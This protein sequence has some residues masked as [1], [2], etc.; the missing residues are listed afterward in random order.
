MGSKRISIGIAG[1][2]TAGLVASLMLRTAFPRSEITVIASSDIGIVGVGEGSTEHW[3]KFLMNCDINVNEMVANSMATHKYGIRFKDWSLKHPDYFHS[4]SGDE[5]VYAWGLFPVYMELMKRELLLTNETSS[6]GLFS[7]E[8]NAENL[9]NATNQFHFDTFKLN[10]YLTRV[11]SRRGVKFIDAVISHPEINETGHVTKV[12]IE[13]GVAVEADFW[14]DAT[15]FRRVLS[16]AIQNTEWRSFSEYLMM[17]S[18]FAFPTESDPSGNIYTFTWAR[19][20]SSGWAWEIPTQER[21]GNG[22]VYCSQFISEDEAVKEISSSV[23]GREIEPVRTFRFDAGHLHQAWVKNVCAVGLAAAFV[24]PLEATSIGSTIQQIEMLIPYIASYGPNHWASQKSYNKSFN[25]MM[26][27][28]LTMIRLHY[29]SDRRDTPF[30]QAAAEMPVN[31]TL[32]ELLDLWQET[33]IHRHFIANNSGQMFQM[34]HLVHVAQGQGVIPIDHIPAAIRNLDLET[35]VESEIRNV[36][37]VR[38]NEVLIDHAE[39]LR[40]LHQ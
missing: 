3:R 38:K 23:I 40:A 1:G 7:G 24:E 39:A 30:W 26:D 37:F 35:Q 14:I 36:N 12:N 34:A 11:A 21:R 29:I 22:Y 18:A 4:V 20:L 6:R 31:D 8:I 25:I 15:G 28:I 33:S 10:Q 5:N 32:Q 17:D 13:N 27:N 19:A 2:G 9:H 16:S